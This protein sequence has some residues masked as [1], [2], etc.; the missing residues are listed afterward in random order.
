MKKFSKIF[1]LVICLI[2]VLSSTALAA[3]TPYETYT[4][5]IDSNYLFSPDA[6][7]PDKEITNYDMNMDTPL[8]N[9]QDIFVDSNNNIYI[10]DTG[11]KRVIICNSE[12]VYQKEITKFTN[13]EGVP[14]ALDDPRGLFVTDKYIY[15]CDTAKARIVLFTLDGEFVETIYSPEADIMGTDTTFRPVSVAVDG[16][17]RMYVVSNQTYSGIF[18]YDENGNFESFIGVQKSKVSLAVKLRRIFFP[19]AII[20][21]NVTTGYLSCTIDSDGFVWA[22]IDTSE[23]PETFEQAV[24]SDD[25][26]YAPIKRLN[27]SGAD[28]MV[29]QGFT[30]PAGEIS[31][32][33]QDVG[34]VGVSLLSDIALGPN[35]LWV[36]VDSLRS[37][38]FAYDKNGV[39]LY[40]F[41]D[42][43]S[44]LGNLKKPTAITFFDSYI[45]VLDSSMNSVTTYK[46]TTY[47]D[48]IDKALGDDLNRNYA[49]ALED[50][51]QILKY[52]VNCDSAYVGVG[53]N[54]IRN[55]LYKDAMT[56]FMAAYDTEN[57]SE[58]FKNV[59]KEWIN[60]FIWTI[61]IIV[62]VLVILLSKALKKVG[63]INKEGMTKTGHRTFVEE[64][65]YA[66][67][68]IVHPFDGF[69]DLKHEKRGSVRGGLFWL[70]IATLTMVYSKV[71]QSWIQNPNK[72]D[73]V[74][75]YQMATIIVP[76]LLWV[77]ANWC[78]T[79]LF[80]GEGSFKDIFIASSYALAP[81]V[82]V[83]IPATLLSNVLT[84]DEMA[85]STLLIAISVIWLV[86][87]MFFGAM[88]THGYSMG[89][90]FIITLC[91]LLG[92]I[93]IAFLIMLFSNLVTRMV[94]FVGEIIT[95]L[96][97]RSH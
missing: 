2:I 68:L 70:I 12:F 39:L 36:V 81:F 20:D 75:F 60:K 88:T 9:P 41:G 18:S 85:I 72:N 42:M 61:P 15:V 45:Y 58:A 95:E 53:K 5:D 28:V 64:I 11:N 55:G 43:G 29:R 34:G 89:K 23:E 57:Y 37:R 13:T 33:G 46:R 50:W 31:F 40:A 47:G 83:A 27:V 74:I 17:G 71:G 86:F 7:V 69:W 48:A 3:S 90:N 97:Y 35:G 56:M 32:M 4:Y 52:N 91:T 24:W 6:Y 38:I 78:L 22:T 16:A 62:V 79:T 94:S 59:R 25:V 10:A 49:A 66:F 84:I 80:D 14:D 82:V 8:N 67:H 26:D 87:L 1:A 51:R 19:N 76:F 54:L 44:Q 92:M 63:K 30:M 96:S 21:E 77:T 73:V 65:L 93:F